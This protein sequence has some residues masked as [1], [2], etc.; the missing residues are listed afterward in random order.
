MI[1]A[2][3]LINTSADD[4]RITLAGILKDNPEHAATLSLQLLERLQGAEGHSGRRYFALRTLRTA[5]KRIAEDN[6][7]DP[8]GPSVDDLYYTLP[9]GDLKKVFATTPVKP[10]PPAHRI[11]RILTTLLSIRG[12]VQCDTRRKVLLAALNKAAKLLAEGEGRVVA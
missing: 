7:P 1:T 11:G 3:S 12:E 6:T 4:A 9:V 10:A 8:K 5:A 2:S